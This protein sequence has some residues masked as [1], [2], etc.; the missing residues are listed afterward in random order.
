M[1]TPFWRPKSE[2]SKETG[3]SKQHALQS[4]RMEVHNI[5]W[6]CLSSDVT[7]S[8]ISIAAVCNILQQIYAYCEELLDPRPTLALGLPLAGYP[9]PY[10]KYSQI[11]RCLLEA[12]SSVLSMWSLRPVMKTYL[13]IARVFRR[14]SPPTRSR[15]S[16]GSGGESS[17]MLTS[18]EGNA[19]Q[20]RMFL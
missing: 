7:V 3:G 19:V 9:R 16:T 18:V 1:S 14:D 17:N 5:C 2:T 4:T 12:V 13:S 8:T 10:S 6:K 15:G 11:C 20:G